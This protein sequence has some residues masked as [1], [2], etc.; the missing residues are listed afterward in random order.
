MVFILRKWMLGFSPTFQFQVGD[1][2]LAGSFGSLVA[3]ESA[4][5]LN[6][7]QVMP[8]LAM[9][10][11]VRRFA[12]KFIQ[13]EM[14]LGIGPSKCLQ[15]LGTVLFEGG[16]NQKRFGSTP[17]FCNSSRGVLMLAWAIIASS[18]RPAASASAW[19]LWW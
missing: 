15:S 10:H 9:T 3:P 7:R 1:D 16:H 13:P 5:L 4:H 19:G 14:H 11:S 6:A 8:F 12:G 18:T 2:V 17:A